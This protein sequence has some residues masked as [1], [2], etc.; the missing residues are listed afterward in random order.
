MSPRPEQI[1]LARR[2]LAFLAEPDAA[3]LLEA[4]G[5]LRVGVDG[6]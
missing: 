6:E 4:A 5:F 3:A 1:E 2:W